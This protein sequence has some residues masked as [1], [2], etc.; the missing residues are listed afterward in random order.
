LFQVSQNW[1]RT[2]TLVASVPGWVVVPA[3]VLLG[4]MRHYIL[5]Q[6]LARHVGRVW[7]R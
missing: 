2:V 4:R 7:F 3:M 6:R 1:H 5:S